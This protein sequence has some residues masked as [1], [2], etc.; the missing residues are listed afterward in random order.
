MT[1][2]EA[3]TTAVPRSRVVAPQQ[4]HRRWQLLG[5]L[6]ADLIAANVAFFL[7]YHLRYTYEV[8][9]NVIGES[10]VAYGAYLPL[11]ALFVALCLF[12]YQMRGSYRS[13]LALTSEAVSVVNT[14]A[15]STMLVFA[16]ASVVHYSASSRLAFIYAWLLAMA[17]G[18]ATRI[19]MRLVRA[20]AHHT[21]VGAERV[22]VVGS[23]RLAR[24]VM[25]LLAQQPTL[26]CRV[27]GF[28]DDVP[29][30]DFGR[31]RTLGRL[32]HL[33]V[34]AREMAADRVIVALPASRHE[35]I[36]EVLE[37]CRAQGVALSLV[38]DLFELRLSHVAVTTVGG[39]PLLELRESGISAGNMVVKRALDVLLSLILIVA[40]GP[41]LIL[42]AIAVRLDSA[43]PIF[44]W[45]TR[46]GR[47]GEPFRCVKFRS[48]R[49]G[50]EKEQ[51]ALQALNE[52]DG[53]IF[54]MRDDPR[55]TRVGRY[56][57]RTSLDELPQLW[58]VLRGEMSL[59]GPRPPI[60]EEVER[61]EDWHRRRLEVVP[62][63]T[64]L[65]QVSGRSELNFDEMVMLDLYYIENWSLGLD[66][67][68]L[69][70]TLPTVLAGRG[71]F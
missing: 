44:F 17:L 33:P 7:A 42:L 51:A 35:E 67:Q 18:A 15:V 46:L 63:I 61:Y 21:G 57:R 19:A 38:P 23:N 3:E 10:Y 55:L 14:T 62:G 20:R 31:F 40:L 8:G 58:N 39:I 32:E 69:A 41:G 64:G 59:I 54:K 71:A 28:V 53:P 68:I 48:M 1:M 50:A 16:F 2:L 29:S 22:I 60:P 24:M 47:D 26:G 70:R 13:R 30:G 5:L 25:Q 4:T 45:Q 36:L 65:W 34:L 56:L 12:G 43:G 52:A 27:L 66:F 49:V 37:Q 11:Q 9:G 6:V